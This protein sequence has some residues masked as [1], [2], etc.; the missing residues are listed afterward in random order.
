MCVSL[1]LRCAARFV[2]QVYDAWYNLAPVCPQLYLYSDADPLVPASDVERY[3][4]V[5]VS[6]GFRKGESGGREL[7]VQSMPPSSISCCDNMS[8][9]CITRCR[10]GPLGHTARW[11][12]NRPASW[13]P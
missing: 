2:V 5:Q 4:A 6:G 9:S 11:C 12:R 3:M 10:L 7:W 8:P 1:A 13:P